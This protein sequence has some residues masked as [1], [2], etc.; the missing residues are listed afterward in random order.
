MWRLFSLVFACLFMTAA[1]FAGVTISS[2]TA[3]AT[4]GSPVNFVASATGN[5]PIDAM[6]IYVDN[7]SMYTVHAASLNTSLSL[8]TGSHNVVVVAW[9][10][11][12][13]SYSKAIGITVSGSAAPPPPPPSSSGVSISAPASGAT[14]GSPVHVVASA[15]IGATVSAMR[16]YL[17]NN[18]MYT[19]NA[20]SIDT[21]VPAGTGGHDLV[22]VAWDTSGTPYRQEITFN[23]GSSSPPPPPPPSGNG[24]TISSPGSG[25]TTSSPIHV[26]ASASAGSPIAAMR[27][28]LDGN[29]MYTTQSNQLD[30]TVSASS[31]GHDLV[32]VAWDNNGNPY[33]QEI[34]VNVSG[35][36][37]GSPPPVPGG[38]TT[39]NQIQQMGGW[40]SCTVCAG[41][42]GSGPAAQYWTQ[43]GV[44]S[45]TLSGSSMEFNI[46]GST[47]W[48]DVLW[49]KDLTPNDNATNYRYDVDFYIKQ[50]QLSQA[51]EFD[52]NVNVGNVGTYF[53]FGTQCDIGGGGQFDVWD[54]AGNRWVPTGAHCGMPA[55]YT[56]HHLTWEFTRTNSQATFVAV[57]LDGV[58]QYIN[59]TFWGKQGSWPAI[60]VAF[61]MDGDANMDTYSVWLDNVT[62]SYW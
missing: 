17:D 41:A 18:N 24:V 3:G 60:N 21:T 23:V 22:I 36:G 51:L 61:Q 13:T 30:T 14:V 19:V 5:A 34:T 8:G 37:G 40:G 56:W 50:P 29:N 4:T 44:T 38:A 25:A 15:N 43:Q 1:A 27:I 9:D 53:I 62:L 48:S 57:T 11:N 46:S 26:V 6:R 58:K 59:Y 55:A 28:Y 20:G 49:W 39:F 12:G 32:V 10:T 2:P 47:P 54:T 52:V 35:G 7:N 42:G 33:K 16:I 45:P 31:G